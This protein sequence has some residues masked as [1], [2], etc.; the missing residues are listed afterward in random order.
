MTLGLGPVFVLTT[1]LIVGSAPPQ[2]AG[3]AAAISETGGELGGVLGIATLGSIGVAIYRGAMA[4]DL[5]AGVPPDAAT[6]ARDTLGGAFAVAM[7]LP[8][9]I[10]AALLAAARSAF[11]ESLVLVAMIC[12]LIAVATAIMAGTILRRSPAPAA[13]DA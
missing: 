13:H 6:A 12:A 8:D 5:P 7:E 2:R 11:S 9:R 3:A 10:G 1:D 4:R